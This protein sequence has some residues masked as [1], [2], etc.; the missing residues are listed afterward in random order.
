MSGRSLMAAVAA[1]T[2]LHV[3]GCSTGP[4]V[5]LPDVGGGHYL[6]VEEMLD[7]PGGDQELYCRM[8]E[9][10]L[11]E[12]KLQR[13]AYLSDAESLKAV[14]DSLKA[15]VAEMNRSFRN[16]QTEVRQLKL[17][18]KKATSYVVREGDTL[19]QISSLLFGTGAR[20]EEIYEKNK[21]ILESPTTPLKPGTRL[22]IPR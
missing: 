17:E 14:Q 16:L 18:E 10:R 21:D 4:A 15:Q 7:L 20:W 8:L 11:D 19:T 13:F 22:Q 3:L 2:V 6:T 9:K 5:E 1:G 12:L